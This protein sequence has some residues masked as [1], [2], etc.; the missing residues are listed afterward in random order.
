MTL[1]IKS[2]IVTLHVCLLFTVVSCKYD[3]LQVMSLKVMS[4]II[5]VLSIAI[6]SKV[7]ISTVTISIVV[8]STQDGLASLLKCPM[9][10]NTLIV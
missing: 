7:F 1:L 4:P 6:I 3:Q 10:V 2:K 8:V 5:S 9:V